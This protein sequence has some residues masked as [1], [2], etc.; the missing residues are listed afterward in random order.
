[1]NLTTF[2][3][4]IPVTLTGDQ[5]AE[6]ESEITQLHE[7]N[8]ELDN[9]SGS[10]LVA[11]NQAMSRVKELEKE[12][13]GLSIRID[14]QR[15]TI[16]KYQKEVEQLRARERE[17]KQNQLPIENGKNRY[18]LDVSYFR[19]AI[20]RELNG[21]LANHKPDELARV[22][23]RLSRT[24]DDSVMYE[25][26]FSSKFALEHWIEAI[27]VFTDSFIEANYKHE[28]PLLG[29]K[30]N[31]K[32]RGALLNALKKSSEKTCEKLRKGGES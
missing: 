6:I 5:A 31:D 2:K 20:N 30:Y 21:P 9:E 25:P 8:A 7:R 27:E 13:K 29:R 14:A 28:T 23:A 19:N 3:L 1:M 26:E 10:L 24:A 15:E 16:R 12:N 22:L 11:Y 17:L 32:M 4:G 18:G